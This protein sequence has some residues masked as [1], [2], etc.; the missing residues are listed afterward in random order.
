MSKFSD[1][2]SEEEKKE[3]LED[4]IKNLAKL[5]KKN[6][7]NVEYFSAIIKDLSDYVKYL[8]GVVE[9]LEG[10]FGLEEYILG[11]ILKCLREL[12]EAA[13]IAKDSPL[14]ETDKLKNELDEVNEFIKDNFEVTLDNERRVYLG[15]S[16]RIHLFEKFFGNLHQD[17][18]IYKKMKLK[19]SE[20]S[21]ESEKKSNLEKE[22]SLLKQDNISE[23]RL[24]EIESNAIKL[25]GWYKRT[26]RLLF[27]SLWDIQEQEARSIA[28]IKH[29]IKLLK[30]LKKH[31]N[32]KEFDEL[33]KNLL[34]IGAKIRQYIKR[35]FKEQ[36][37]IGNAF[38][39]FRNKVAIIKNNLEGIE[40]EPL[41]FLNGELY[42]KKVNG[43]Y[44]RKGIIVVPGTSRY[45]NQYEPLIFRLAL[46]GYCVCAFELPSQGSEGA[47]RVGLMS[48]YIY[49]CVRHLRSKGAKE[50]GVVGHSIGA[51]A[52]LFAL[53]GYNEKL[54]NYI[55]NEASK[56]IKSL[57]ATLGNVGKLSEKDLERID[58]NKEATLLKS[59]D[60]GVQD[61]EDMKR[62]IVDA[63]KETRFADV[64]PGKIGR[65]GA[66]V[67]LAPPESIQGAK[68]LP[69]S[70]YSLSHENMQLILNLSLVF[71]KF[72]DFVLRRHAAIDFKLPSLSK[73]YEQMELVAL[74]VKKS[75]F[76]DFLRYVQ[77]CENPF[78][79][80]SLLDYLSKRSD[81]IRY[82]TQKFIKDTPKLFLYGDLDPLL[83]PFIKKG[84]LEKT[85]NIMIGATSFVQSYAGIG[86]AMM[87]WDW[88]F[89]NR[90]YIVTSP[91]IQMDT[92]HFFKKYL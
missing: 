68:T 62:N 81:F 11:D 8:N 82:Y 61:Y 7:N 89:R 18:D 85:Y 38:E 52:T 47:F 26:L 49:A 69:K 41:G 25:L 1:I 24:K 29:Y 64:S 17:I 44:P 54:E 23:N 37:Y 19:V 79:F 4:E 88:G 3:K 77:E 50:V 36:E 65:I 2:F 70:F 91:N 6:R 51:I 76:N 13:N 90:S 39:E 27:K 83:K 73:K 59:L 33:Y 32:L 63:I 46:E 84:T 80:A 15:K 42:V 14:L 40:R 71:D 30:M 66:V 43:Q 5:I 56:Y 53:G 92:V 21:I 20:E 87:H 45:Y 31:R 75:E 22:I 34:D 12:K 9:H 72:V 58:V 55:I 78:D 48:T 16:P 67:L 35:D 86:H 57:K 74:K 60:K 10:K 28:L